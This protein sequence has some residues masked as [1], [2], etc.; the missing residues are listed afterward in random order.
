MSVLVL[1]AACLLHIAIQTILIWYAYKDVP[2]VVRNDGGPLKPQ[3]PTIL[4]I[5][6]GLMDKY[7]YKIGLPA[8][9]ADDVVS[10]ELHVMINGVESMYEIMD[11]TMTHYEL[12]LEENSDVDI[13]MIDIDDAGNRSVEGDHLH[14]VVIDIVPPAAPAAPVIAD[15]VLYEEPVVVEEPVVEEPVVEEPVIEEPVIEEPVAE[16]PVVE[17][18]VIEEPVVEEPVIEEPVIEEPVAEEPVVEEP[19]VEDPVVEEP[20]IEEP[21]VEEPVAEEPVVEEPVADEEPP[22]VG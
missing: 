19:V 8:L 7:T 6:G 3:K 15:V 13:F 22:V 21:V 5:S 11:V 14:F 4:N 18:P 16:E 12:V 17:E 1:V 9:G 20:V 2:P 10:R